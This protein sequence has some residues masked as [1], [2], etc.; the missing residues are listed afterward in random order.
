MEEENRNILGFALFF[1]C[2]VLLVAGGSVLL[3]LNYKERNSLVN[4]S[5]GE[6]T[7]VTDQKKVDKSKDF[8]YYT[9]EEVISESLSITSKIPV[10]NLDS[11]DAKTVSNEVKEYVK[12]IKNTLKKN[13]ENKTCTYE[14]QEEILETSY[15]DYGI[16]E[17]QEYS[18]LFIR[19]SK[20][21]CEEGFSS[22]HY[23][24]AYTFDKTTGKRIT[25]E[26]LLAKY[27]TTLT[28]VL[29]RIRKNLAESQTIENDE[30]TIKIEETI[31]NLKENSTFAIY[32]DEF[33]DLVMNY[34]VKTNSVD[35]NDSITINE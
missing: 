17:Y 8:I 26:E 29:D 6:E 22:S 5:N 35:Y 16:Y 25:K 13:T 28:K 33:G 2:I 18:T 9:D 4:S 14:N 7:I 20:Y 10:I 23:V 34:V 3:F 19:E 15:L 27:D 24:K 12:T 11:E 31:G 30:E 1:F 32:I 21:S